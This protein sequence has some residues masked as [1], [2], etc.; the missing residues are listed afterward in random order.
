M[1]FTVESLCNQLARNRLLAPD[2]V[3]RMR[4]RWREEAKGASDDAGR[5]SKWAISS[6]YLTDFQLGM[7]TRGFADLL[8]LGEYKLLD[9]IGQGRM[10]GVYKG[11]HSSGQVVA[12]K[13]LPPSKAQV[14]Q[15]LARFLREARLSLRLKHP[16]VVRTFQ[17]GKGKGELNFI[18]MEHLEGETLEDV[19]KRR[20]RL[21]ALEAGQVILQALRGLQHLDEEGLVHRDLKPANLMLV[22]A[23]A[24]DQPDTT[25]AQT[26][27]ILD[28][29]LGRA[30]FDEGEPGSADFGEL[31][32]AGVLLGTPNYMAPEQAR[33]AHTADIRADI[34]SLGCVQY[35]MLTGQVPFPDTSAVRQMVRHATEALKPLRDLNPSV[36]REWQG[37]MDVLLAKDPA[38]RFATANQAAKAIRALLPQ[39][40]ELPPQPEPGPQL[41]TYLTWL[42]SK[43]AEAEAPPAAAPAP[44]PPAKPPAAA[45]AP[46][47]PAPA[48]PAAVPP[49]AAPRPLAPVAVAAPPAQPP[50]P[51][52][53]VPA[54]LP[55]S[56]AAPEPLFPAGK[57]F[58]RVLLRP[59]RR[60]LLFAGAGAGLLLLLELILWI[61]L[62]I[63][64]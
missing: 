18:V 56:A 2:A 58:W 31:T 60:D 64:G 52:G 38:Q 3:R 48:A 5:F 13:V 40:Q 44:P 46:P 41:R 20:G 28:I 1:E 25:L 34:Y 23:R 47:V 35:E 55:A 33:N 32:N 22:P 17:V 53:P 39:A 14:P 4:Q 61:V 57:P 16:N 49:A 9:R 15:L 50:R 19:L 54:I 7:L 6:G 26:V 43:G 12:V 29:G 24:R 10:A 37:V 51:A 63:R 36:P 45:P 30:L 62:L 27:K 8:L 59:N 21:P 11:V 42:E